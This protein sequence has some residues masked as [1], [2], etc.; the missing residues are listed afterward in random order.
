SALRVN[1]S[2]ITIR[3]KL[4]IKTRIAGAIDKTVNNNKIRIVKETSCGLSDIPMFKSRPGNNPVSD[5]AYT[6]FVHMNRIKERKNQCLL[7]TSNGPLSSLGQ[8]THSYPLPDLLPLLLIGLA[9]DL[10]SYLLNER[11]L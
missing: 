7:I 2:T 1:E 6:V 11:H 4:V 9:V 10:P 5:W 8:P 3:V